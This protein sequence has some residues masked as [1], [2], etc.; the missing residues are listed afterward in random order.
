MVGSEKNHQITKAL[1]IRC[2]FVTLRF[3]L[4]GRRYFARWC[5]LR[6]EPLTLS[7]PLITANSP[8]EEVDNPVSM[9]RDIR[10]MGDQDDGVALFVE[11]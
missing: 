5:G 4:A 9:L 7:H 10:F 6:S 2:D 11:S 3:E 1:W 8:V